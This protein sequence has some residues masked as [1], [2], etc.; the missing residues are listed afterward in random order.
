MENI[1][2]LAKKLL[3]LVNSVS[4]QDPRPIFKNQ[5]YFYALAMD[6]PKIKL[7]KQFHLQ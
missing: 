2:E 7:M 6:N 4:L 5:L 3:E 1:K